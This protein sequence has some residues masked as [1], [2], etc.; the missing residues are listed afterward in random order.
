MSRRRAPAPPARW[1]SHQRGRRRSSAVPPGSCS[2][3]SAWRVV[4]R[5]SGVDSKGEWGVRIRRG[6]G[7]RESGVARR[8]S[9]SGDSHDQ[10]RLRCG[11]RRV[12][13]RRHPIRS[14]SMRRRR[15]AVVRC[16]R[17][18]ILACGSA[19]SAEGD[20]RVPV[21]RR[22]RRDRS[23]ARRT[24]SPPIRTLRR[25]ARMSDH[26]C[27]GGTDNSAACARPVATSGRMPSL[28]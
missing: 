8:D 22:L 28:T 16:A 12:S 21:W 13:R 25:R 26:A 7:S 27:S 20:E 15:T 10:T 6:I 9:G 1:R 2:D 5:E 11:G 17:D 24:P 23:R 14:D 3:C 19:Q 18:S 4:I